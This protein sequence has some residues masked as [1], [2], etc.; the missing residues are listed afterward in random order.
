MKL[1][2]GIRE[3]SSDDGTAALERREIAVDGISLDVC[4]ALIDEQLPDGW[5]VLWVRTA[6]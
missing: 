1:I 6:E 3:P 2:A 5:Q 4:R